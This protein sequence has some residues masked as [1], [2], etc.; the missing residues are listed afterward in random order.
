MESK[1]SLPVKQTVIRLKNQ[2]KPTG[3]NAKTAG[4]AKAT[5]WYIVKKNKYTVEL[6]YKVQKVNEK[7]MFWMTEEFFPCWRKTLTHKLARKRT[8]SKVINQKKILKE[9]ILK[10]YNKVYTNKP[11]NH[12][13]Q[14]KLSSL[15]FI[16]YVSAD[17]Y[18]AMLFAQT[19]LV[20]N[21]FYFSH[22]TKKTCNLFKKCGELLIM[23]DSLLIWPTLAYHMSTDEYKWQLFLFFVCL[24]FANP[25]MNLINMGQAQWLIYTFIL[26]CVLKQQ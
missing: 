10:V 21:L 18:R 19:N 13:D 17:L 14:I 15:V 23:N 2:N 6:R 8:P 20:Y 25:K 7:K 4:V 11:E 26:F 5:I 24:S 16:D 1:V 9:L 22:T 3:E 12:E